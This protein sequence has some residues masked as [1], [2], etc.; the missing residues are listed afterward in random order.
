M[1][2]TTEKDSQRLRGYKNMP[3]TLKKRMFQAPI[4]V[5]FITPHEKEIFEKT[6]LG[7]LDNFNAQ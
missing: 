4:E 5:S 2:A 3:E 6:L 7:A 1:I